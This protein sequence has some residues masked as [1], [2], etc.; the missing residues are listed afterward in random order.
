MTFRDLLMSSPEPTPQ[1]GAK[2]PAGEDANVG[3]YECLVPAIGGLLLALYG[4][5]RRSPAGLGLALL[6]GAL[7]YRGVTGH[8]QVYQALGINT[9]SQ[10]ATEPNEE[11]VMEAS[12]ESFPASDPPG[13]IRTKVAG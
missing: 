10:P 5:S 2:A 8:C 6:G 11:V 3:D 7:F 13:W 12:E 4:L 1:P 9:A